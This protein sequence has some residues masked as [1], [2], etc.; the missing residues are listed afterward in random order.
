MDSKYNLGN[1]SDMLNNIVY[2]LDDL[3]SMIKLIRCNLSNAESINIKDNDSSILANKSD[4]LNYLEITQTNL[5]N[6]INNI[7]GLLSVKS[8]KDIR[9]KKGGK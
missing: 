2:D 4:V 6:I 8:I 7:N 1:L 9:Y 5:N 3:S